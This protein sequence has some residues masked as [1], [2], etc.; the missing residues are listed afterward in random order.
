MLVDQDHDH[1]F[2]GYRAK[3]VMVE[4]EYYINI[5]EDSKDFLEFKVLK[6]DREDTT[7][8]RYESKPYAL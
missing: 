6:D 3:R 5:H 8:L 7:F 1:Y 2:L 4:D